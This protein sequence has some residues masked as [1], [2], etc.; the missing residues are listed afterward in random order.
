MMVSWE[1]RER[2]WEKSFC[3]RPKRRRRTCNDDDEPKRRPFEPR[4]R[5]ASEY[6]E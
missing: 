2:R 5:Y 6:R 1:S 3:P 4:V